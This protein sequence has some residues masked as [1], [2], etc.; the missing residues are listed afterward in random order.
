MELF[1]GEKLDQMLLKFVPLC[2]LGIS[3]LITS[4]K[5]RLNNSTFINCILKLEALSSY[6]YIQ[7][8]CFPNQQVRQKVYLFKIFV[9][10]VAF[11]F[12]LV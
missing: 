3:D 9:N 1:K 2:S 6:D 8:S 7:D 4:L 11:I 5:H 12:D 10:G